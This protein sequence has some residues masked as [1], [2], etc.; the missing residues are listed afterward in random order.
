M[1]A[2]R[3]EF[4]GDVTE[5]V[6]VVCEWIPE[7]RRTRLP[8]FKSPSADAAADGAAESPSCPAELSG[9][10]AL[11]RSALERVRWQGEWVR[12]SCIAPLATCN[13]TPALRSVDGR[14]SGE[15]T[16]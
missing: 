9:P 4:C 16:P 5:D 8:P 12:A 14:S 2:M 6:E 11:A 1:N 10:R 13:P 15:T 3:E 7:R